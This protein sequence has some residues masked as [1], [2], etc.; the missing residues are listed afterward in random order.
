MAIPQFTVMADMFVLLGYLDGSEIDATAMETLRATFTSNLLKSDVLVIDG[1]IISLSP[2]PGVIDANGQL[3]NP[4]ANNAI[5][6]SLLAD[7]PV[8]GLENPLEWTVTFSRASG[9]SYVGSNKVPWLPR[10]WTFFA[11]SDGQLINLNTVPPVPGSVA[12]GIIRGPAGPPGPAGT[13]G[14]EH[15]QPTPS[16]TWTITNTLGRYPG[17]VTVII[18]GEIV[19]AEVDVPNI[20][21]IAITF[22][23][24]Q[25]GRAEIV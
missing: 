6:V 19:D 13:G 11:G 20:S 1:E 24:P 5:G 14:F 4:R 2:V 9:A 21:T 3:V 7:D 25:S 12:T 22:A 8:L 18:G 16:A 15:L 23:I 10:P 17:A